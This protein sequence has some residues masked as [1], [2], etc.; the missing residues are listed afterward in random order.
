MPS[1]PIKNANDTKYAKFSLFLNLQVLKN[2]STTMILHEYDNVGS[3]R[4]GEG[5]RKGDCTRMGWT[6]TEEGRTHGAESY[7]ERK[8]T[9]FTNNTVRVEGEGAVEFGEERGDL[10]KANCIFKY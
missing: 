10:V 2:Y 8:N 9:V 7:M 5:K 4:E 1:E 6:D 3:T